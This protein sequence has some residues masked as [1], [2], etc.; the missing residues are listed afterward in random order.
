[1]RRSQSQASV[2]AQCV[3]ILSDVEANPQCHPVPALPA[4]KSVLAG[5]EVGLDGYWPKGRT[6][7]DACS[8][9]MTALSND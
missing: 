9:G 8:S 3:A 5:R 7:A 1:M 2:V 6:A 4:T